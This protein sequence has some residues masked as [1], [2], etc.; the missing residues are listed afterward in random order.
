[1][2]SEAAPSLYKA[3]VSP[4]QVTSITEAGPFMAADGIVLHGVTLS[5]MLSKRL[6]GTDEPPYARDARGKT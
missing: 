6:R 5:L 1:M 4:M 3:V 2:A